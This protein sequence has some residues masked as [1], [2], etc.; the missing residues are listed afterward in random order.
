MPT[1]QEFKEAKPMKDQQVND[2][3]H[4]VNVLCETLQQDKKRY[5]INIHAL[6][7]DDANYHAR[8]IQEIQRDGI[9]GG[10]EVETGRKYHKVWMFD[11]NGSAR[12]S[13]S[14][15][16]FIDKNTGDVYKPASIKAPAKGVRFN[17]LD[18]SSREDM[19]ERADWAGGYLYR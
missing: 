5:I 16:A 1:F 19:L 2:I 3:L 15:H 6:A 10:F 7:K 11:D 17:L 18:E 9:S 13:R 12:P 8:K 4:Y 14:I